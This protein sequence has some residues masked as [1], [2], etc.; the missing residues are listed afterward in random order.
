MCEINPKRK[1]FF[2]L[3]F[4]TAHDMTDER[5]NEL[6][7]NQAF[8]IEQR[9]NKTGEIRAHVHER[10]DDESCDKDVVGQRVRI[11]VGKIEHGTIIATGL[12]SDERI[13][14]YVIEC[15]DHF[16]LVENGEYNL[17]TQ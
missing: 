14:W 1:R 16:R 8:E 5:W 4:F 6:T 9:F 11:T 2:D 17:D 3:E 7:Y 13:R 10:E 12:S 15:D